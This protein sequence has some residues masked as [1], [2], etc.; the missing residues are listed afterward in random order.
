M[1]HNFRRGRRGSDLGRVGVCCVCPGMPLG[2]LL[3]V[4]LRCVVLLICA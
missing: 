4:L 1:L 2:V 3:P